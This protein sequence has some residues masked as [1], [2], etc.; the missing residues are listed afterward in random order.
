MS[1]VPCLHEHLTSEC[2]DKILAIGITGKYVIIICNERKAGLRKGDMKFY[3]NL[4]VGESIKKP[5]KVKWKLRHN[6]GQ[7]QVYVIALASGAD[8]L[9]IYHCAFLQQKYY[10]KHPPYIIG[11]A[12]GYE[13]AV[14]LVVEMT[15]AALKKTGRPDL[16]K[17]L[18]PENE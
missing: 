1:Q 8:Q 11:I 12:G 13:E 5:N 6:A 18:F 17:Y 14:D 9:E 4:Y 2:P 10:K 15:K 3:K 7:F 16:T